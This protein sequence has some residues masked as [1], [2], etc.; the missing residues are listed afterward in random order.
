MH[1]RHLGANPPQK[2]TELRAL[3]AET[4]NSNGTKWNSRGSKRKQMEVPFGSTFTQAVGAVQLKKDFQQLS[5]DFL[6]RTTKRRQRRTGETKRE[7]RKA[8]R[9]NTK[10]P[11][12]RHATFCRSAAS[13]C[14]CPPCSAYRRRPVVGRAVSRG[15]LGGAEWRCAAH[16]IVPRVAVVAVLVAITLL[17]LIL[18]AVAVG[19]AA[20]GVDRTLLLFAVAATLAVLVVAAAGFAL[21]LVGKVVLFRKVLRVPREHFALKERRRARASARHRL[22][23][24]RARGSTTEARGRAPGATFVRGAPC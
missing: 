6:F 11:W 1:R 8:V 5:R 19:V 10:L 3:W 12:L 2:T 16:R 23:C 17:R 14:P 15:A 21:G 9:S 18:L 24:R 13:S 22:R 7:E 20:L 4:W